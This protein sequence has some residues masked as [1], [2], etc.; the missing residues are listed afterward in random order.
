[1]I[2]KTYKAFKTEDKTCLSKVYTS[3]VKFLSSYLSQQ[4]NEVYQTCRYILEKILHR[5][6]RISFCL[7]RPQ[8][9]FHFCIF[10][11]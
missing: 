1:M 4:A 7:T 11:Q 2:E 6:L 8:R 5:K 9:S 3:F 10:S